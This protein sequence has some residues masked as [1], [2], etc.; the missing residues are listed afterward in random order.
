MRKA[1]ERCPQCGTFGAKIPIEKTTRDIYDTTRMCPK[2]ACPVVLF[3]IENPLAKPIILK[4][5]LD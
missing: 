2:V 4:L 1:I 5:L 3:A